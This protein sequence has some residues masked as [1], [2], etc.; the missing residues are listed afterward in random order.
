MKQ[1]KVYHNPNFLDYRG[2]HGQIVPPTQPVASLK[3]TAEMP[4]VERLSLAF[5]QTQHTDSAWFNNPDVMTHLRSTS[6]G[7]L[8]DDG[9]GNLYVVE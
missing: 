2:N 9:D 5:R 8:I 4:F 3:A 6:V 7:D 1:I